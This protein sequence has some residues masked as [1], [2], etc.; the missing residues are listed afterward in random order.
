[1]KGKAGHP[2]LP[3][4]APR[5]SNADRFTATLVLALLAHALLIFGIGFVPEEVAKPRYD[6]LEVVLV[7]RSEPKAPEDADLLAQSNLDGGGTTTE[8][9]RPSAP[10]EAP[11]PAPEPAPTEPSPT[12][13]SPAPTP[14]APPTP[15]LPEAPP[16]PA[17]TSPVAPP[18]PEQP[19]T[20]PTVAEP[21]PEPAPAVQPV[22]EPSPPAEVEPP[23]EPA[24]PAGAAPKAVLATE[25]SD[26][27]RAEVPAPPEPTERP[28]RAETGETDAPDGAAPSPAP[29][30]SAAELIASSM[31]MASLNAELE[32]RLDALAKRP[33]RKYISARTKEYKYAAYLEAWRAK[34]ERLGNLNYPDAARSKG[35]SGSLLLDVALRP[36]GSVAEITVRRSSGHKEL[37]DAAVNIVRLAAPYAPFPPDIRKEVDI[38][39]ITRTWQFLNSDKFSAR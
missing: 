14:P 36:D 17:E 9:E 1:M 29:A 37:D 4:A 38:L 8:A 33:R 34:V 10:S 35:L 24:E 11:Y 30:P 27:S 28:A 6:A 2:E 25:A 15:P 39:H 12:Q 16:T 31:A 22:P 13:D 5:I 23:P 26:P 21:P 3:P 20:E 7:T 32:Q 18:A 19:D